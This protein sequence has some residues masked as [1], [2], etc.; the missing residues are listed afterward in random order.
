MNFNE[1]MERPRKYVWRNYR[2]SRVHLCALCHIP[3]PKKMGDSK[4]KYCPDCRST[5]SM[6]LYCLKDFL[7]LQKDID[8]GRGLYCSRPC[9][10]ARYA[11]DPVRGSAHYA[12]KGGLDSTKMRRARLAGSQGFYTEQQWEDLKKKLNYTCLACKRKE[13]E[14][15]LTR[16]HI[17]PVVHGGS[18][19]ISN[20]QPLCLP[21]NQTKRTKTINYLV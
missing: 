21:C 17:V 4:A 13:P 14:I 7:I 19:F 15:K 10:L 20:I 11:L 12:W 5:V 8:D 16:D 1:Q 2:R 3:Y 9:A 6:C 18:N